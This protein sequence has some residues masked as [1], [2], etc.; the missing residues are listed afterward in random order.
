MLIKKGKKKSP[1]GMNDF[2]TKKYGQWLKSDGILNLKNA[3]LVNSTC[4]NK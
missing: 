3:A 1:L 2:L 4:L